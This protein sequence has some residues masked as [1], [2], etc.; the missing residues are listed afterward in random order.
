VIAPRQQLQAV[1]RLLGRFGLGQDAATDGHDGVGG[2]DDGAGRTRRD[3][4][5]LLDR[6]AQ[7]MAP[8]GLVAQRRFIDVGGID[9]IRG[10]ADLRQQVQAPGARAGQDQRRPLDDHRQ[11]YLKR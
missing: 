7:G 5:R 9:P 1:G 2:Q 6:Q 10:D 11:P 8:R 3:R 4:P